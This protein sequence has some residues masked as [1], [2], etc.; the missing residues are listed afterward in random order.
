M[1]R[2]CI[3][4]NYEATQAVLAERAKADTRQGR[5]REQIR[6]RERHPWQEPER[7]IGPEMEW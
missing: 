3:S 1:L 4:S 7:D 6:E 5:D 2:L